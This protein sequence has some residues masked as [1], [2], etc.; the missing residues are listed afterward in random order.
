MKLKQVNLTFLVETDD[1]LDTIKAIDEEVQE[2][3]SREPEAEV[4]LAYINGLK[5]TYNISYHIKLGDKD[6]PADNTESEAEASDYY[7]EILGTLPPEF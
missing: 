2:T 6:D 5:P 3:W 4:N 7:P 1:I